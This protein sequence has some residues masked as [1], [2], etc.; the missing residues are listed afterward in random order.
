MIHDQIKQ[1]TKA[2]KDQSERGK[3]HPDDWSCGTAR[4]KAL[5]QGI[6][7]ALTANPPWTWQ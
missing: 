3:A 5:L 7:S 2:C 1:A 4:L 6:D